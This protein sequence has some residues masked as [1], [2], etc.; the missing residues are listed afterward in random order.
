MTSD[1]LPS[2]MFL[3][4]FI[5]LDFFLDHTIYYIVKDIKYK[6]GG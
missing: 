6:K 2:N 5:L 4:I 3:G 1:I